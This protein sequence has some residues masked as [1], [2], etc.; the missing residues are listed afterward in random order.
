MSMLFPLFSSQ[1]TGVGIGGQWELRIEG[2]YLRGWGR[3]MMEKKERTSER[4][5]LT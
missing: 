2:A 3:E 1:P 5:E 4:E